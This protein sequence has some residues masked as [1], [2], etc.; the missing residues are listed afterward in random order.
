MDEKILKH[1]L[2]T[3]NGYGLENRTLKYRNP[4]F[5]EKKSWGFEYR[6]LPA[7]DDTLSLGKLRFIVETA[8]DLLNNL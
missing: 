6:S 1:C 2:F 4:G 8:F 3:Q 7:N 5:Y